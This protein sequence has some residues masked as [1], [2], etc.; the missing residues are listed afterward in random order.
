MEGE[1]YLRKLAPEKPLE[2]LPNQNLGQPIEQVEF[3]R[4]ALGVPQSLQNSAAF[5]PILCRKRQ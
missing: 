1:A 2:D 3:E 4:V 5:L